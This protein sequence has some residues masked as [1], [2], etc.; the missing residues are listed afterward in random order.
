MS[1]II[2]FQSEDDPGF[3]RIKAPFAY[4]DS[5]KELV[6]RRWNKDAKVW[7]APLTSLGDAKSRFPE[8]IIQGNLESVGMAMFKRNKQA[9]AVKYAEDIPDCFRTVPGLKGTLYGYQALGKEFLK[10]LGPQ[11][12]AV[13]G[14]DMGLG[15]TISSLATFLELYNEGLVKRCFI[16]APAS[17]KYS[18]WEKEIRKW[19]DLPYLII[20][21]NPDN[22]EDRKVLLDR[23]VEDWLRGPDG[24]RLYEMVPKY[25]KRKLQLT[26]PEPYPDVTEL[27]LWRERPE[28][29]SK[30]TSEFNAE[31]DRILEVIGDEATGEIVQVVIEKHVGD[32]KKFIKEKTGEWEEAMVSMI[33]KDLRKV[34]YEQDDRVILVTNYESF[35][36]DTDIMPPMNNDW[37]VI[38]DEAHRLKNPRAQT[39][40]NL[41]SHCK[42]AARKYLLSGTPLEN[43]IEELWSIMDFCRDGI[44]GTNYAFRNRYFE[45]D[46][47]NTPIMVKPYLLPELKEK[48]AP[49]IMRK[50][51]DEVLKDLPELIEQEYWVTMTTEQEKLYNHIREG[52]LETEEE[53]TYLDVLTQLT[54][55]QQVLDSP[56]LLREVTGDK[57]LPEESGKLLELDNILEDIN[58]REHKIILFSQFKQMTDI[59]HNRMIKK[60]GNGA[61]RYIHGGVKSQ[62]RGVYQNDFQNNPTVRII[63]LTTAGNYG[64]DLYKASYVICYDQLFNPQKMNQ[65]VSRAHRHGA[66]DTVIA[67]HLVTRKSYEEKKLKMLEEK[68]EIFKAFIDG[69]EAAFEKFVTKEELKVLL[70]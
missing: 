38:I 25:E 17:L 14:F 48:M 13:L 51:K 66:E 53:V 57:S 68:R 36:T 34:Q 9:L 58:L 22:P 35:L 40:K 26:E 1:R 27:T 62:L 69:D 11:E 29:L 3:F 19:T 54:R 31:K 7:E 60:F 55:I 2:F 21:G 23:E 30:R 63:I 8:A 46:A 16:V 47:Y 64:L 45:L 5:I 20:D 44:F 43:N 10:V 52:I 70:L 65:V 56:A 32:K 61:I 59:L 42:P 50:R 6:G 37:V 67:L 18:A 49:V 12:G 33:G 15:K 4:K 39:T 28:A 41:L 24:K